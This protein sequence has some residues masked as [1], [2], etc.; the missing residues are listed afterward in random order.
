MAE[1]KNT[2]AHLLKGSKSIDTENITIN[3][4]NSYTAIIQTNKWPTKD[5]FNEIHILALDTLRCSLTCCLPHAA[6]FFHLPN[7]TEESPHFSLHILNIYLTTI[8]NL[9]IN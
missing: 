4:N 3:I 6:D 7:K 9:E 8:K 2:N 5:I 1:T